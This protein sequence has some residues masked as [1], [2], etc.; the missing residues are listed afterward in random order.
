[1]LTALVFALQA[2]AASSPQKP[3]I[4]EYAIDAD[5]T[6]IE[7]A[8]PFALMTVRRRFQQ[9]RGTILYDPAAPE[10]SSVTVVIETGSIDTGWGNRD[11]HLRTEDF[12]DVEKYP[13]ITFQSERVEPAGNGWLATGPLT[14]RGVTRRIAIPFEFVEPPSRRPESLWM[15]LNV[16]G[17]VRLA[18]K[19]FGILGGSTHNSWFTAA[20]AATVGDTVVI[21]LEVQ[22]WFADAAS[23]RPPQVV[24]ALDRIRTGGVDE[25]IER[26]RQLRGNSSDAAF[27]RYFTGSAFVVRALIA[28]GRLAE[29]VS[30]SRGLAEQL[31]PTLAASWL[32]HGFALDV[33]GDRSRSAQSYR[34]ARQ[35]FSPPVPDPGRQ[36]PQEDP[37]WYHNDQLA[38][39]AL[40]WGRVREAGNLARVLAGIYSGMASSHV[41]FGLALA[42]AGDVAGARASYARAL[43][44][45]PQETRAIEWGRRLN[46]Q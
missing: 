46:I 41:T 4:H 3:G 32:L 6:N 25:T 5:H 18:R 11:R 39:T 8:I 23:Q 17:T 27:A 2:A 40:E 14:M 38:R 45:D 13:T 21:S 35:V 12:F 44:L 33:S 36:S 29:A 42:L 24:A 26:L 16:T 22:G 7:F 43:V 31:F 30:L 34:R 10:R 9:K 19:D 20:R 28:D 15:E 1:M 37:F